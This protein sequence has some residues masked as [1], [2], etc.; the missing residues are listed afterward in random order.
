ML[1]WKQ[2]S[3]IK[4][5]FQQPALLL[6]H[7]DLLG[8][9]GDRVLGL[10]GSR[11]GHIQMLHNGI[12]LVSKAV[13]I[14]NDKHMVKLVLVLPLILLLYLW[15]LLLAVH[16]ICDYSMQ[17]FI[18]QLFLDR[19]VLLYKFSRLPCCIHACESRS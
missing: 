14:V 4:P 8:F 5:L 2:Y 15:F 17:I 6:H 16:D 13:S 19:L 7:Y 1:K 18:A 10:I 3:V 11:P 9:F 12:L